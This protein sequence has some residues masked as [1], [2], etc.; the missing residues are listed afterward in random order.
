MLQ[1]VF[2][3]SRVLLPV[4]HPVTKESA[5]RSIQTA[6][7]SGADGVFL[8]NQGK[9]ASEVLAFVREVHQRHEDLWLG[10]DLLGTEP[11]DVIGLVADLPVGGIWSDNRGRYMNAV[12][13]QSNVAFGGLTAPPGAVSLSEE[14]A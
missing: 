1:R 13:G 12:D 5:L 3:R 2:R 14:G 10:V 9:S 4:I 11:E 6:V 7:E 8:I